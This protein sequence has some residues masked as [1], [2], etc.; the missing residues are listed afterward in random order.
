MSAP[1]RFALKSLLSGAAWLLFVVAGFAFLV[2]GRAISEFWG[3]DRILAEMAG[4]GLAV[5]TGVLGYMAKTAAEDINEGEDSSS[6]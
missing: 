1:A 3:T 6:Q 4:I 2:G 5:V